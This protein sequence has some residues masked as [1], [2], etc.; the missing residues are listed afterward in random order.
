M[1]VVIRCT[2]NFGEGPRNYFDM[3]VIGYGSNSGVRPCLAGAF[4]TALNF[5]DV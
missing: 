5:R 1:E 3:G 4:T 2:Q